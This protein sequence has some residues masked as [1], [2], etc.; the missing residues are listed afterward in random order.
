MATASGSA[1]GARREHAREAPVVLADGRRGE[2]SDDRLAD[3]VV[4]RLDDL[5]AVAEPGA[6]EAVRARAAIA[7]SSASCTPDASATIDDGQG[8]AADGDDLEQRG[9]RRP[10]GRARRWLDHL[11]ERD[12]PGRASAG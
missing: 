11:L 5:A 4:A 1:P 7:S 2:L 8:P 10:G 9:A 6:H 3:A 12:A